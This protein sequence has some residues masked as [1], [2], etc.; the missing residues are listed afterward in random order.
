[1]ITRLLCYLGFH[2]YARSYR[3][4]YVNRTRFTCKRCGAVKV[5]AWEKRHG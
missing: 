3:G 2:A 5:S 4:L 1:M